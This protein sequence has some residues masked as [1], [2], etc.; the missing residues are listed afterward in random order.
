MRGVT[1][2]EPSKEKIAMQMLN[3]KNHIKTPKN[4]IVWAHYILFV[5]MC[6]RKIFV[7]FSLSKL[8]FKIYPA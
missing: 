4:A 5:F 6:G 1:K 2:K 7:P 8:R 3:V